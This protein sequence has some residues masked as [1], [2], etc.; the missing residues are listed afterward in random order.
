MNLTGE[1]GSKVK[2]PYVVGGA[3]AG[4]T[5]R[6]M[7]FKPTMH[8]THI[9]SNAETDFSLLKVRI[10]ASNLLE[11]LRVTKTVVRNGK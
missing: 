9:S 1:Y 2:R 3:D 4:C 6:V 11:Y 8:I 5:H 7:K 10:D